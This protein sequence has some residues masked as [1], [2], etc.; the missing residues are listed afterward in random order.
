M[1]R[2]DFLTNHIQTILERRKEKGNWPY[3]L[4]LS[5]GIAHY[6]PEAPCTVSELIAQADSRMYQQKQA[7]KGKQ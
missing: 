5:L 2:A 1:E 6:D 4:A 3:Q 7:S